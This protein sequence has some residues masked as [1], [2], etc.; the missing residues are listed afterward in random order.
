MRDIAISFWYCFMSLCSHWK[1]SRGDC[2]C[3]HC[4]T[5][6]RQTLNSA[7]NVFLCGKCPVDLDRFDHHVIPKLLCFK[8]S[9]LNA[10]TMRSVITTYSSHLFSAELLLAGLGLI[11][12]Q[13][14]FRNDLSLNWVRGAFSACLINPYR[15]TGRM[16]PVPE[17][18]QWLS[19]RAF[20][21]ACLLAYP[22]HHVSAY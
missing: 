18:S 8:L 20:A 7:S 19:T 9:S 14:V 16:C 21:F 5:F 1:V 22:C 11:T 12:V 4:E 13:S 10:P 15:I 17:V 6:K 3:P 2:E